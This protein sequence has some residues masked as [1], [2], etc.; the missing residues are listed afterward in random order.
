[1]GLL[2]GRRIVGVRT[3]LLV[4]LFR[5]VGDIS[6]ARVIDLNSVLGG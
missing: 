3:I 1:M 4:E 2:S 5:W 6:T